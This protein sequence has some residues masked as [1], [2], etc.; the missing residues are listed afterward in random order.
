MDAA[1]IEGAAAA[2]GL[3]EWQ[4]HL[5][6]AADLHGRESLEI[7]V[8]VAWGSGSDTVLAMAPSLLRECA[9]AAPAVPEP[10][11]IFSTVLRNC[12]G[13]WAW[14]ELL[15][16]ATHAA[17]RQLG[18]C[19]VTAPLDA[20]LL[21]P[22]S[23][24]ESDVL[25]RAILFRR[26]ALTFDATAVMPHVV[27][28]DLLEVLRFA[29]FAL[30]PLLPRIVVGITVSAV[31]G[32][33]AGHYLLVVDNDDNSDANDCPVLTAALQAHYNKPIAA[34]PGLHKLLQEDGADLR[35][36]ASHSSCKQKIAH[37]CA[38]TL[39]LFCHAPLLQQATHSAC[40]LGREGQ[41][42]ADYERMYWACGYV[43]QLVYV[44][45]QAWGMQSSGMGCYLDDLS[46]SQFRLESVL[47]PI[48][49][50]AVGS[51]LG[52]HPPLY[53]YEDRFA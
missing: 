12:T 1:T 30:P 51:G 14:V 52:Q 33:D 17:R 11:T 50:M 20:Q 34:F 38:L 22:L 35:E 29:P 3:A 23:R 9:V 48:Y 10:N 44:V 15:L 49:H 39:S 8:A 7:V 26:S 36:Q 2:F 24:L 6:G 40:P 13:R 41:G 5:H 18:P 4:A 43:G 53:C 45:A 16:Q 46:V 47:V 21:G 25:D 42:V 31:E 32:V 19:T 37:D 28:Q 27:F